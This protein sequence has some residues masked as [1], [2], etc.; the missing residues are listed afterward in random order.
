MRQWFLSS[1]TK[2]CPVCS[3]AYDLQ[4]HAGVFAKWEETLANQLK[5]REAAAQQEE[6]AAC[7]AE[8]RVRDEMKAKLDVISEL[9]SKEQFRAAVDKAF[10]ILDED[11]T[12]V[13]ALFL[14]G[15]TFYKMGKYALSVNHLMKLVKLDFGYP[16]AFFFLGRAYDKLELPGKVKW[17]YQCGL[18]NMHKWAEHNALV[19]DAASCE[20]YKQKMES[21]LGQLD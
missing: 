15:K 19:V 9:I 10:D 14:L 1:R 17:A 11:E 20:D 12:Q 4:H 21:R 13:D 5:Q 2:L 18:E 3:E 7:Q 8:Q 16:G 6:Y